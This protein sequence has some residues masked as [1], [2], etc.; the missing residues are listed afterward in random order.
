MEAIDWS[1]A[2]GFPDGETAAGSLGCLRRSAFSGAFATLAALP[3]IAAL[4]GCTLGDTKLASES[5]A[6]AIEI[7]RRK[8]ELYL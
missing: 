4:G 1:A 8:S 2:K 3:F 6:S 5:I 7:Q